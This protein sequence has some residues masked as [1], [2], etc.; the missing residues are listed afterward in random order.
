MRLSFAFWKSIFG[1]VVA[2]VLVLP[3]GSFAAPDENSVI[4]IHTVARWRSE[5]NYLDTYSFAS[6][7]NLAD[8]NLNSCADAKVLPMHACSGHG[9][10][11]DWFENSA[12]GESP[13]HQRSFC[14]CDIG[15]ADPE[16]RT[17]RKSQLSAFM[18]SIF[19]GVFGADQFYLGFWRCGIVKLFTLGGAGF[20]W[21]FDIVRIGSTAVETKGSFKVAQDVHH[22]TFVLI[23]IS[24][25]MFVGFAVSTW[26]VLAQETKKRQH[27]ACLL[28]KDFL[29]YDGAPASYL[30]LKSAASDASYKRQA[31]L[32]AK[33]TQ[34]MPSRQVDD[35]E[36]SQGSFRSPSRLLT[37]PPSPAKS[38]SRAAPS[39]ASSTSR[40]LGAASTPLVGSSP[41]AS[42]RS[43]FG[44]AQPQN[45]VPPSPKQP[46]VSSAPPGTIVLQ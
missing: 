42:V 31:Q 14:K 44:S 20:W 46:P 32:P 21:I 23:V 24:V 33:V 36:A 15:W 37:A 8:K 16:C 12:T 7:G 28:Q 6:L 43:A 4:P 29:S 13:L 18:L 19:F 25:S 11:A 35:E 22:W 26:S 27:E 34:A 3:H 10:C 38:P 39:F 17:E 5:L 30:P 45:S 40:A 41:A 2:S 1:W 9:H